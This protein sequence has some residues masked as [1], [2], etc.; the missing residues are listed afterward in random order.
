MIQTQDSI[1]LWFSVR[2]TWE[3]VAACAECLW[4]DEKTSTAVMPYFKLIRDHSGHLPSIII[5]NFDETTTWSSKA[6]RWCCCSVFSL[7]FAWV[8]KSWQFRTQ[9]I[10]CQCHSTIAVVSGMRGPLREILQKLFVGFRV[11]LCKAMASLCTVRAYV[12]VEIPV[13]RQI[14][15]KRMS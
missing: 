11:Y 5:R 15:P 8:V 7:T 13:R 10:L 4:K 3:R 6:Y 14:R 9:Y 12:M 2:Q 1:I